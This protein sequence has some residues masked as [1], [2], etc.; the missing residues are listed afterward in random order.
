MITTF[1]IGSLKVAG[2]TEYYGPTHQPEAVFPDFDRTRFAEREHELPPGHWYPQMDRLVIAIQIWVLFYGNEIM[3]I[4]AGV[5]NGKDR[6]AARM[7]R[8]NTL[9]PAWLQAVGVTRENVTKVLMTHLH[10]DHIGWNTTFENGCWV[11]TFPNARYLVPRR[12]FEY[13]KKLNASG[14]ATEP[15]F[16]DSLLPVI[17]AGLVDLID[18]HSEIAGCL[19]VAAATGHTPGMLNFWLQSEGETGVFCADIFHHPVQILHPELN[20]A[21]CILPD[22]AR[23]TRQEFLAVAADTGAL[24]MPCHFPPPHRGYI[25]RQGSG[26]AYVAAS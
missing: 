8:L 3:I 10:G 4:D 7:H 23:R 6:P 17:E 19:R 24:V 26:F 22:E 14:G 16:E 1:S 25:R 2:I 5:G 18:E 21:F 15:S 9:V 20:T 12:D 13:F 11:P